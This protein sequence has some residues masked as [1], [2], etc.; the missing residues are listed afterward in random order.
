MQ[1]FVSKILSPELL[2]QVLFQL[3]VFYDSENLSLHSIPDELSFVIPED[4]S[5]LIF[6]IL[7]KRDDILIENPCIF[8][9]DLKVLMTYPIIRAILQQ[10]RL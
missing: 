8:Q 4:G 10:A 3:F 1:I 9:I 2:K 7:N 5:F 6:T